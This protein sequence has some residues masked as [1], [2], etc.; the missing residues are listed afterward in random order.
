MSGT[1]LFTLLESAAASAGDAPAVIARGRATSFAEFRANV[2]ARA[3]RLLGHLE[4]PGAVAIL[5]RD[6][7]HLLEAFFACAAIGRPAMPLDPDLPPG[8]LDRLRARY[9]I[10]AVLNDADAP[11]IGTPRPL[12]PVE[13]SVEF[14]WGLTSGTTGEPKLFARSHASWIA[15]FEAAES[16]FPF[17]PRSRV[18]IPGPLHQSLFLYGA[19]HALC[20]GHAVLVPGPQFR[21][22]RLAD[23]IASAT[24]LYAVPFMLAEMADAELP[25]PNLRTIFCGGAKLPGAL[26]Q[27]CERIWPADLVEFYGASETSFVSFH[28]TSRPAN[29]GSVGWPFPGVGVEMRGREGQIFI[30]SPMLFSRYVG[31]PLAGPSV[32]VGDT[33]FLDEQGALHLTGRINRII[34]SKAL[35]LRPEAIEA[36]LLELPEIHRAAVVEMPD[37]T[38]GSVAAAAIEFIAGV[39]LPRKSLSAHCR[40]K[41]GAKYAPSLYYAADRLPLTRSGKLAVADIRAA[42]L[43][44]DPA[45]RPLQ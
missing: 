29:D 32:S 35:K 2:A 10:A 9:P 17:P 11:E 22:S 38:R 39:H 15:S 37:A 19:V 42:L 12:P 4:R 1:T 45:F 36:A 34:N 24:H 6:G 18:L 28:S 13:D 44:G 23:A 8:G 14:Y 20:R 16:V 5:A 3:S 33:G 30:A 40:M 25:A 26:R 31:E 43:S 7:E 41:L 27:R 21:T